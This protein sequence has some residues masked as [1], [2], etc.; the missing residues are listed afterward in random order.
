MWSYPTAG[1]VSTHRVVIPSHASGNLPKT[2]PGV[3]RWAPV[4]MLLQTGFFRYEGL[5]VLSC[6]CI[7]ETVSRVCLPVST[8]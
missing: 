7:W 1:V 8:T 3:V 2:H 5:V 6:S 4:S